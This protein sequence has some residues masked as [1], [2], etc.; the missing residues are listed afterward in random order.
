MNTKNIQYVFIAVSILLMIHVVFLPGKLSGIFLTLVWVG[1]L[2]I[3]DLV[4]AQIKEQFIPSFFQNC[5]LTFSILIG[6]LLVLYFPFGLTPYTAVTSVAIVSLIKYLGL[7]RV[8]L[9]KLNQSVDRANN[10]VMAL[11]FKF[12]ST[13]KFSK[14]AWLA[15]IADAV[16]VMLALFARTEAAIFSPWNILGLAP[17]VLFALSTALLLS[18]ARNCSMSKGFV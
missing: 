7:R 8:F 1:F 5:L 3:I 11:V 14:Y 12:I 18:Q 4:K 13:L 16:I 10:K 9:Y 15:L 2:M 17:F 6:S